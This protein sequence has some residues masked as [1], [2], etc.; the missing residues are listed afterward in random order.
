VTS[1]DPAF[2]RRAGNGVTVE[3]RVQ[4]RARRSGLEAVGDALKASVTAPPEDGKANRAVIDLLAREWHLPRSSFD[5]ARGA[6]GRDK[7]LGITGE[8]G[9]IAECI[10][11]WLSRQ[12]GSNG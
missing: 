4:P 8:P 1:R 12:V 5:V 10:A 11:A 2:L 9:A 3:L 7:V 6:H